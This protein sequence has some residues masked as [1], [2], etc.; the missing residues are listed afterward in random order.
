MYCWQRSALRPHVDLLLFAI[1]A[2]AA[3]TALAL[4]HRSGD[5]LRRWADFT[6]C[7]WPPELCKHE[8]FAALN[9]ASIAL[10]DF[11][12]SLND[13]C[14]AAFASET[15][16]TADGSSGSHNSSGGS[17][18]DSC[19]DSSA[20]TVKPVIISFS[21]Y[22]PRVELCPEKRFLTEPNLAKVVG[23]DPLER[24]VIAY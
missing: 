13:D 24:Q 4:Q 7:R 6:R 20:T 21:H 1:A 3:A 2:A 10:A 16:A 19:S 5:F 17:V 22:V 8:D 12:A 14:L 23:S 15:A 11:F 9:P 18:A